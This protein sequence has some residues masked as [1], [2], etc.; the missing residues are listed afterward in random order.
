MYAL[1]RIPITPTGF[2]KAFVRVEKILFPAGILK[3]EKS[4]KT[5]KCR[6]NL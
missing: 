5:G 3:K 6:E 2:L 4:L 1:C